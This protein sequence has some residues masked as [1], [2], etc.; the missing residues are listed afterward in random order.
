MNFLSNHS[1][2]KNKNKRFPRKKLLSTMS[3][4]V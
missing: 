4:E 1:T 2:N 3:V